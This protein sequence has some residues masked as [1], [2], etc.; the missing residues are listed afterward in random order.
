MKDSTQNIREE[1]MPTYRKIVRAMWAMT[2]LAIVGIP[3]VFFAL[4]FTELPSIEELEN[5]RSELA[6]A[7]LAADGSELGRY[8][9]ENRIPVT[10]DE[11]SPN[12]VNA[13]VA[14]ED[15]R[16][17]KHSGID[18]EALGRILIKT[19]LLR[20]KNAGG[21][22]TITQQLAKLLFTGKAGSGVDRIFQKLKEWIIAVRLERR[23]TKEEIIAMY[24]NK[25]S[26]LY[27]AYGIKS[28][29]ETYFG[30]GQDSLKIHQAATLM[31]MLKNPS[32]FNPVRRPDTVMHR[33]MVVLSQ[34]KKNG[35][36]TQTEYDSI[37]QLP[38]GLNFKRS[39]H[40][41]GLAPYFRMEVSKELNRILAKEENRKPD[42]SK[43]DKYREGLKIY[44]TIDPIIQ[45]HAEAAMWEHMKKQQKTFNKHWAGKDPWTYEVG[46]ENTTEVPVEIRERVLQRLIRESDR[47]DNMRTSRLSSI[48]AKVE[49]ETGDINL[50]DVDIRRIIEE[51][52]ESG[53]IARLVSNRMISAG[54]AAKYRKVMKA[55]SY[56]ELKTKYEQFEAAVRKKFEQPTELT[57]FA[58]NDKMETDTVMSPLDSIKYHRMFLQ[59]GSMSV[60]PVT[61]H[62]KSWVGGINHKYFQYDHV[63][64]NVSRQ[65]GSTFKPFIY[66]TAIA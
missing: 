17:Y 66:A 65:V 49:K 27:D 10:Y 38:L 8:Y 6:S 1:R 29:S 37:R 26:F 45:A 64:S 32:L 39:N 33:R 48:I 34:M 5:P 53:A 58:Y 12:I 55:Q 52:K 57:V 54:L 41:D 47:Y 3:L 44:T 28:A 42:G 9:V 21:G 43:Y 13:L 50:R 30:V 56:P 46:D 62:V 7:V 51:E 61:G 40:T 59:L 22:S 18:S 14:T 19:A 20:N 36:L 11:L 23:Y 31:G 2:I 15:E 60:D 4:S 16:F 63:N 25:F 24:L 35:L